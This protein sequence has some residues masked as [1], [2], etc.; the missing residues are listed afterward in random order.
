MGEEE[1]D[2]DEGFIVNTVEIKQKE[3]FRLNPQLHARPSDY[4]ARYITVNQLLKY[5]LSHAGRKSMNWSAP[6]LTSQGRI[7]QPTSTCLKRS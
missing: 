6:T 3:A 1:S 4:Q 7:A 2:N 5:P